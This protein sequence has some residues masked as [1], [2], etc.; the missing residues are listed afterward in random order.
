[1]AG[2]GTIPK[3]A[4]PIII[5]TGVNDKVRFDEP[6]NPD[7]DAT[8]TSGTY[9]WRFDGTA[10]DF[11][12]VFAAALNTASVVAGTYSVEEDFANLLLSVE[13]DTIEFTIQWSDT[14]NTTIDP[15]I[16]GFD[17]IDQTSSSGVMTSDFQP[18][19]LWF[20]NDKYIK[21]S[22]DR[23]RRS[24]IM[25]NSRTGKTFTSSWG[26]RTARR[27]LMD[28]IPASRIFAAEADTNEAFEDFWK[29]TSTGTRF[30]FCRDCYNVA[31]TPTNKDSYDTY[32]LDPEEPT[33]FENM[34]IE[35]P[36]GMIRIYDI[37]LSM[38]KYVG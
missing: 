27:I 38:Q 8:I 34:P 10:N 2:A 5:E 17:A 35:I 21:D 11:A 12:V 32:V 37:D 25:V 15:N 31:G 18:G 22:E 7:I 30:E 24:A 26:L 29:E 6:S 4:L 23:P 13:N 3:F 16:L 33:Q 14:T 9:W 1:M 20:P 19:K 36:R 28:H